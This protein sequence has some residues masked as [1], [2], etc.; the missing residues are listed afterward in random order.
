[1]KTQNILATAAFVVLLCCSP[2]KGQTVNWGGNFM[3]VNVQSDGSSLTATFNFALGTF[4][5]FVPTEEN[6]ATWKD[7]W[8]VIDTATYNEPFSF[9]TS[10]VDLTTSPLFPETSL[11]SS[12]P[13]A[14]PSTNFGV[15]E[16]AYI[17]IYDENVPGPEAEWALLTNNDPGGFDNWI[18]PNL[19]SGTAIGNALEWRV[20][21]ASMAVFGG[22]NTASGPGQRT[23]GPSDFTIQTHNAV[24]PIPEPSSVFG[25]A[26]GLVLLLGRRRTSPKDFS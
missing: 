24:L 20:S 21:T 8:K 14:N 17:W 15:G 22:L 3:D 25:L 2:A 5:S 26:T 18:L 6:T 13:A 23:G 11:Q 9:F 12:S 10:S 7:Y 4:G 19:G 16:Q 1:L